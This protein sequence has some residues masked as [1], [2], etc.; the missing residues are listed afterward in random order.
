[1]PLEGEYGGS[2]RLKFVS[3]GVADYDGLMRSLEDGYFLGKTVLVR[4][5]LDVPVK[6]GLVI[7][8]QRLRFGLSTINYLLNR[9][10]KLILTGHLGRPSGRDEKL[11]LRP[12]FIHLSALLGRPIKFAQKPISPSTKQG[13]TK[14][15]EGEVIALENLRFEKGEEANS[16]TFARELADLAE[17]FVNESFGTSHRQS[18]STVAIGEFLPSYA[19]LRFEQEYKTLSSLAAHPARP[20]VVIIGGAKAAD[21]MPAIFALLSRSDRILTGGAVANQL[22]SAT[23]VDVGK[24]VVEEPLRDDALKLVRVSRGKIILPPDYVFSP[25]RQILDL[26]S[27]TVELY[28]RHLNKAR[29]VVWAGPLGR[30]EQAEYS[31]ASR[32]LAKLIASS[33]ATSIAGGGDTIAMLKHFKLADKFSF[34]SGG[35]SAMLKL[36]AGEPLPAVRVLL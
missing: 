31:R 16:R 11:S 32:E 2:Q 33:S 12:V 19:G 13:I 25:E 22:L 26:G 4:L 35:G 21:K 18:A 8:D 27:K 30:Y 17:A 6:E 20:Y 9:K 10:A 24:S 5:D 23:G 28:G 14:L 36:I 29:T 7:D 34:L 15:K 1:M 3:F